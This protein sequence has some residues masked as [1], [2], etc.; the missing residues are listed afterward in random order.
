MSVHL[1]ASILERMY[2]LALLWLTGVHCPKYLAF[3]GTNEL[4]ISKSSLKWITNNNKLRLVVLPTQLFSSVF[5][6]HKEGSHVIAEEKDLG[7]FAMEV[8]RVVRVSAR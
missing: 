2:Q 3:V 7:V 1:K 8:C 5:Q 4:V 6:S